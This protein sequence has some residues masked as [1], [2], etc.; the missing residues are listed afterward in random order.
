MRRLLLFIRLFFRHAGHVGLGLALLGLSAAS[1][2][3][4]SSERSPDRLE[5]KARLRS[6]LRTVVPKGPSLP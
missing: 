1:Q 2:Q 6:S 3:L 4:V 5:G